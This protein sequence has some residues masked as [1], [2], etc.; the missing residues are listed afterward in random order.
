MYDAVR[1]AFRVEACHDWVGEGD[2]RS[3][4]LLDYAL[5]YDEN[6][7]AADAAIETLGKCDLGQIV[8][9]MTD[10]D[11]ADPEW[12]FSPWYPTRALD[13]SQDEIARRLAAWQSPPP[14]YEKGVMAKYA[15]SVSSASLARS[16]AERPLAVAGP[17]HYR[18]GV[19]RGEF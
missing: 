7:R 9:R 15:R 17:L 6:D 3:D 16:C 1:L 14:T 5:R 10:A 11:I 18:Y 12:Q 4:Y 13:V 19:Y 8:A 2:E